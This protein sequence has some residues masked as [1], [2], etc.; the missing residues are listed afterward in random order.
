MARSKTTP[1]VEPKVERTPCLCGC[2][3]FPKGSK[4]RFIPGHDARYHAAQKKAAAPA[5]KPAPKAEPKAKA[6]PPTRKM[7]SGPVPRTPK[8]KA[9]LAAAAAA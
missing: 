4:A 2:G 6:A 3:G 9:V 8:G 5:E 1:A 7:G